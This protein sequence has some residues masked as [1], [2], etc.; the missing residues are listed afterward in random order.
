MPTM[1]DGWGADTIGDWFG[2]GAERGLALIFTLAGLLG[3]VVT[4]LAKASR[5]YRNLALA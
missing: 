3:V 2:A 5:S 1:T 4:L